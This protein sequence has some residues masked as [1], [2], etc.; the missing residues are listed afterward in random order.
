MSIQ[1]AVTEYLTRE[2]Q[3]NS[4]AKGADTR[5]IA[6]EVASKHGITERALWDAVLDRTMAGPC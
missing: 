4:K 1:S 2:A 5:A 6:Q 3:D